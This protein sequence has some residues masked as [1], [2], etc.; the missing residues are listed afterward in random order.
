[1]DQKPLSFADFAVLFRTRNQGKVLIKFMQKAG[2]PCQLIERKIVLDH[3]G[4]KSVISAFKLLHGLG[5]FS[6]IQATAGVLNSSVSIKSIEILNEWAYQKRI[7]LET[8]LVQSCRLPIPHMGHTRQQ[9]LYMFIKRLSS[10]KEKIEGL[11]VKETLELLLR[12]T[13]LRGKYNGDQPFNR[14]STHLLETG[15][16]Y[17]NDPAGFLAAIALS[18]D[19][20]IY[21]RRVEKVALTTM[22]AAK[23]LEF[24]VVFISGCE[25][26]FIPYRSKIHPPDMEEERRLFYVA[27]TRAKIH[28]FL[29]KADHRRIN[30]HK[31]PRQLSPFLEDIENRYK[32]VSAPNGK[33]TE[34][35]S[36]EQLALF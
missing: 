8:A 28:L 22:H 1:M 2:I 25:D 18:K 31:Q 12:K 14:G 21:D 17:D 7:P 26:G 35:P 29:T 23:G 33:N 34:K 20:D 13:N 5:L 3:P 15:K 4:I 11:S 30:G 27:L 9:Q 16:T 19:A 24:P 10:F 32:R 6:D 36:Q